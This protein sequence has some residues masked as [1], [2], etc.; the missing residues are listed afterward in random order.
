MSFEVSI[1][2]PT[3][4]RPILLERLLQ[5]L[6]N[7]SFLSKNKIRCHIVDSSKDNE[8][9]KMVSHW[10]RISNNNLYIDY[11]FNKNDFQPIDNWTLLL[12]KIETEYSK[13]LCDDDW[14][15]ENALDEFIKHMDT[16]I[17]CIISNINI[18]FENSNNNLHN[19]YDLKTGIVEPDNVLDSFLGLKSSIPV[20]QSASFLRSDSLLEAFNFS[21][22]NLDCTNRLF[23]EDLTLNYYHAFKNS[24]CLHLNKS[25]VNSWAGNDS[26]TLN[27]NLSILTYCNVLS[28]DLLVQEFGFNYNK[29]Q[30]K[31]A[32]H[33]LFANRLKKIFNDDY[34]NIKYRGPLKPVPSF[35]KLYEYSK[36]K[37]L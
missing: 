3:K 9:K 32:Q 2:V 25:L 37:L 8:T 27:S 11:E 13:F 22:K 36:K 35:N 28:L 16:K 5:S 1:L 14:L 7:Q 18:R 31:A 20:T 19:Y 6:N 26:L 34:G 21:F 23:G 30:R 12:N 4:N 17:N 29:T 24:S 10:M 15:T 33:Y